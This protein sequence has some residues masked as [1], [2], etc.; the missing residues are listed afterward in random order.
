MAWRKGRE[1]SKEGKLSSLTSLRFPPLSSFFPAEPLKALIRRCEAELEEGE[2]IVS[3]F[4]FFGCIWREKAGASRTKEGTELTAPPS[5]LP[6]RSPKWK[7]SSPPSLNLSDPSTQLPSRRTRLN[8][9]ELRSSSYVPS[10]LL[11]QRF[12]AHSFASSFF[13]RLARSEA[14][15][16][17]IG[18]ALFVDGPIDFG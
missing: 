4:H 8:W 15:S 7:S 10:L 5:S 11:A 12:E 18:S 6:R 16:E 9:I 13:P 3:I 2:E 1:G 14:V 17:Q